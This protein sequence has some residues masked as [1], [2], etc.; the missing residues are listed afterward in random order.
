MIFAT[1][2]CLLIVRSG[3]IQNLANHIDLPSSFSR[4]RRRRLIQMSGCSFRHSESGRRHLATFRNSQSGRRHLNF[5]Q[6]KKRLRWRRQRSHWQGGR[7]WRQKMWGWR[8]H[9]LLWRHLCL[10]LRCW[11]DLNHD[12]APQTKEVSR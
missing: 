2:I 5:D 12:D 8:L 1:F 6:E 9:W 10:G 11:G 3:P 4:R 7:R